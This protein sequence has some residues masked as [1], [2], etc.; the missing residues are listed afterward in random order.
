MPAEEPRRRE[1]GESGDPIARFH[2][3]GTDRSPRRFGPRPPTAASERTTELA[4]GGGPRSRM[5]GRRRLGVVMTPDLLPVLSRGKHRTPRKG[6]CFM[7]L[8]SFLAGERW[9][10]HPELHAPARRQCRADGERLD[11]RRGPAAARRA[12]PV[13]DRHPAATTHAADVRIAR[14]AALTATAARV[15]RAPAGA[16]GRDPRVRAGARRARGSAASARS[17][18]RARTHSARCPTRTAGPSVLA[19]TSTCRSGAS[20]GRRHPRS[21]GSRSS[22]SATRGSSTATPRCAAS[23]RT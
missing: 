22:R 19:R 23:S 3:V 18:P 8:A 13:G 21:C 1:V 4:H 5:E 7:E 16:R 15:R 10:D 17:A 20:S 9:S 2:G 6:A 14:R 12:D 11:V